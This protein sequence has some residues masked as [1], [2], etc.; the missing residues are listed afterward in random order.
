MMEND[1]RLQVYLARSGIGS[2]RACERLIE[3]G[4][5]MVNGQTIRRHGVKVGQ[6]DRVQVDGKQIRPTSRKVYVALHKPPG[7][8]C[9]NSDPEGRPPAVELLR[10]RYPMRIFPVGRLDINSSGLILF[11]NDGDFAERVAHP[12]YE[13]EKEYEVQTRKPVPDDFL[14]RCLAGVRVGE[15]TY[16]FVGYKRTGGRSL[17][18]RLVEGKNRELRTVFDEHGYGTKRV[19]RIRVGPV[20]LGNLARGRFRPL[21][22]TERRLLL[23]DPPSGK[24][25]RGT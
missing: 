3:E 16:R 24:K 12:S 25:K 15:E 19:H 18:V 17:R 20:E 22:A 2:R 6:G 14:E 21:T 13:V 5:V 7:Y 1:V 10:P 8:V 9:S 4:R 11:T 23:G